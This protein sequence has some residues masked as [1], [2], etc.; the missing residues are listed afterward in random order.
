MSNVVG[1]PSQLQPPIV[2]DPSVP[3]VYTDNL[4]GLTI[5]QGNVN[6]TFATVRADHTRHPQ[7]TIER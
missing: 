6:L 3:E 7:L 2:D 5:N 4:A 1:F